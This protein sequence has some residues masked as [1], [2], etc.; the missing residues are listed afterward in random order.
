[1]IGREVVVGI[2]IFS[3]IGVLAAA[4]ALYR[5]GRPS[6]SPPW[7]GRESVTDTPVAHVV[8]RSDITSQPI[9]AVA[10]AATVR[11]LIVPRLVS[12]VR[13]EPRR[14]SPPVADVGRVVVTEPA[15]G[16][17]TPTKRPILLR[18]IDRP[19]WDLTHWREAG[20]RLTGF[21]RTPS[22]SIEGY[23]LHAKGGRPEF[24]VV[25]PP[26]A[27]RKHNHWPCFHATGLNTNTYSVHLSPAPND[28]D[29]G[30]LAVEKVLGEALA[31]QGRTNV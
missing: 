29:T 12:P 28:P 31:Q 20:D 1:V 27:L 21:Y 3:G 5:V 24:F 11:P 13:I 7:I 18:P 22:G 14:P 26:P 8:A 16:S 15:T 4:L 10:Q 30:I 2:A 6:A 9:A 17:S 19:Y 23:V 25:Q